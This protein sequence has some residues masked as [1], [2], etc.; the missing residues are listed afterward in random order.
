MAKDLE[1]QTREDYENL[2]V[3]EAKNHIRA[4]HPGLTGQGTENFI[5]WL[6]D[7]EESIG[8][9]RSLPADEIKADYARYLEI[10]RTK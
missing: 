7:T 10:R 2:A 1:Q 5:L 6:E 4:C 3:I 8:V 9:Y